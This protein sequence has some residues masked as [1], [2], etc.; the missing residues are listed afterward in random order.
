MQVDPSPS[1]PTLPMSFNKIRLVRSHKAP[2]IQ[3]WDG[4]GAVENEVNK[5]SHYTKP[6]PSLP[7]PP[8]SPSFSLMEAVAGAMEDT[9]KDHL[10]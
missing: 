8:L 5:H 7:L 6:S 2:T 1:P 9:N 3:M 10:M 4:E